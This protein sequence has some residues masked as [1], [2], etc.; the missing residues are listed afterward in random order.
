MTFATQ[1]A[2]NWAL[3]V[4]PAAWTVLGLRSFLKGRGAFAGGESSRA[5]FPPFNYDVL[6]RE[7]PELGA[8]K[9]E[10]SP[11]DPN[12]WRVALFSEEFEAHIAQTH[13]TQNSE[14]LLKWED[15]KYTDPQV[16]SAWELWRLALTLACSR[17]RK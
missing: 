5:G 12:G 8:G 10:G 17:N 6:G 2:L 4:V 13:M 1:T 7:S 15:R 9:H 14:A 3:W 11:A 16:E